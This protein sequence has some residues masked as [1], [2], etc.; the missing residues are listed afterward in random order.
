M[1]Q[2]DVGFRLKKIREKIGLTQQDIEKLSSEIAGAEGN[3]QYAIGH[4]HLSIIENSHS[5]P[6][7]YKLFSLCTIYRLDLME[8]LRWY[9]LSAEKSAHYHK[10]IKVDFTQPLGRMTGIAAKRKPVPLPA[11]LDAFF[12][13]RQTQFLKR[14]IKTWQEVPLGLLAQLD[15]RQH[16]YG[17]IGLNDYFMYPM[18]KPG[19]LVQIDVK[20][21]S[22]ARGGWKTEFDRP[23]YLLELRDRYVCCW[24]TLVKDKLHLVPHPLSPSKPEIV[25]YPSGVDVVGQVVAVTMRL[26]QDCRKE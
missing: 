7:I 24:C 3:R 18:L 20:R 5:L 21:N 9:G 14:L 11:K 10:L 2:H 19:S 16:A 8:I 6:N 26:V 15:L 23:I 4:S 13:A 17:F 25:D 12:D 22:V 1:T